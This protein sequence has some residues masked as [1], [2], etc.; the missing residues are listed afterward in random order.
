MLSAASDDQVGDVT[1]PDNALPLGTLLRML[2]VV[3]FDTLCMDIDAARS[4][5][6]SLTPS[7]KHRFGLPD[8]PRD[9]P[10]VL[11]GAEGAYFEFHFRNT[12]NHT[13]MNAI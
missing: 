9:M 11:V 12:Q 8:D 7:E 3:D 1:P 10:S 13:N 4:I 2:S 6:Q 5:L